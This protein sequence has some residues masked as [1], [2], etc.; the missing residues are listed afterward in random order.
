M[1]A[2]ALLPIGTVADNTGV[3]AS[4]VRY[5]DEIG[6]TTAATRIGGKRRF[7][8]AINNGRP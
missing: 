2:V 3:T 5:Y 8:Q 4:A 7:V 6:V 1:N